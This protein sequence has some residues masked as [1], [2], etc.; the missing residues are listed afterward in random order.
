MKIAIIGAGISGLSAAY[1]L[2]SLSKDE[3]F[4]IEI[5]IFEKNGHAGGNIS[6]KIENGFVIEEGADSFITSKPWGVDLCEKLGIEEQLISTNDSNRKTY[7]Y[8]DQ[9]LNELPEGFFLMAPSNI[10]AFEKST[11]FST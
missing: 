1:Y 4:D 8:F 7:I 6:T 10:E 3:N 11:F 5:D 9:K 2:N